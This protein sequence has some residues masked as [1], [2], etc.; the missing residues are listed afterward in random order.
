MEVERVGGSGWEVAGWVVVTGGGGEFISPS[1][2]IIN[3][4]PRVEA[5]SKCYF[6]QASNFVMIVR[7]MLLVIAL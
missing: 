7:D 1:L 3:V 5:T 4:W 6:A 2:G